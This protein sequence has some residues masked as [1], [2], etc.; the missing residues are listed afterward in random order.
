[1]GCVHLGTVLRLNLA[2]ENSGEIKISCQLIPLYKVVWV[3]AV[4]HLKRICLH[5]LQSLFCMWSSETA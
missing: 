2:G 5:F 1:M 3:A 4:L